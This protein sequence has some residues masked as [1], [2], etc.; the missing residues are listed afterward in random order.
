MEK[1]LEI[2]LLELRGLLEKKTIEKT[3]KTFAKNVRKL[4]AMKKTK[5]FGRQSP[6]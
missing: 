2:K 6:K 3:S 4:I 1:F 5:K